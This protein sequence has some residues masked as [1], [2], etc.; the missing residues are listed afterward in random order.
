MQFS[1]IHENAQGYRN[2]F[3][4]LHDL[5]LQLSEEKGKGKPLVS[6]FR[7][8]NR[9][10]AQVLKPMHSE[11]SQLI[12]KERKKEEYYLEALDGLIQAKRAVEG[13]KITYAEII[14]SEKLLDILKLKA[15]FRPKK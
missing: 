6:W 4:E 14:L 9:R 15:V 2:D 8:R 1:V 11:V 7:L 12:R 13:N 3:K 5:L 10:I